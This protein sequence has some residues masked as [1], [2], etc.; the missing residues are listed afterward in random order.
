MKSNKIIEKILK[1]FKWEIEYYRVLEDNMEGKETDYDIY[2]RYENTLDTLY[3][4]NIILSVEEYQKFKCELY[5]IYIGDK[6]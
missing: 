6:Q 3:L 5:E 1:S 4:A 2:C